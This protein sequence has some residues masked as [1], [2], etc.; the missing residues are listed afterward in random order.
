MPAIQALYD[1]SVQNITNTTS[2]APNANYSLP[3]VCAWP[4]SGQYGPGSRV[5]YYVLVATCVF[6]RKTDWLRDACLAAALVFPAVAAIHSLVL[7]SVHVNGA[8]DLDIYGTFQFCS[9]AILAAPL[10]VRRSSTYFNDPGRNI[11]FLWTILILMGLLA[12]C[13]EFYRV[14]PTD[15][16]FDDAGSPIPRGAANFPYGNATCGMICSEEQTTSPMRGGAASNVYV[17]PVPDRL[18]FNAAMLLAAGF[19]IPAILS[20]IFTWDKILEINWKRRSEADELD[21]PIEGANVTVGEMRGIN[22]MVRLFLSVVEVPVFGGAVLAILCIGEANFF[23]EQ[24]MWQTEPMA[25]VGQW[26][27]IAGT[28]LAAVGSLYIL[29][30]SKGKPAEVMRD[31]NSNSSRHCHSS[32]R[33]PSPHDTSD[34]QRFSERNA[35]GNALRL[36]SSSP[37]HLGLIPT[38][39]H[40]D[41]EQDQQENERRLEHG[42]GP[43][44]GRHRVRRWFTSAADYLGQVAH[45][46]LDVSDY[47]DRRAHRFPVVPGEEFRNPEIHRISS[48]FSQI[49]EQ[50]ASIYAPSIAS[51]SGIGDVPAPPGPGSPPID[52]SPGSSRPDTSPHRTPR[53]RDT[54]E[55]PVP[56]HIYH[57]T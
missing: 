31:A 23:S 52:A 16:K 19:C 30:T 46:K 4:T 41:N 42:D 36:W 47:N 48:Q 33:N 3:V 25:S 14:T 37:N 54:L 51:T 13:V 6:A 11:I 55:V 8:V 9:I 39:T 56:A 5:L 40:P 35:E 24:V 29:W 43:S 57:R 44:A 34:I 10:T 1:F 17:I 49:R 2:S 18:T 26:A 32:D 15:C 12:L 7:A 27:P 53:R 50:R 38:I 21:E 20:L 22:N 45:D 28:V